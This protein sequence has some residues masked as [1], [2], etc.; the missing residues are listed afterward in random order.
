MHSAF[1]LGL[2]QDSDVEEEEE[3]SIASE[4][5]R[6]PSSAS[7]SSNDIPNFSHT[8]ESD[9]SEL[10]NGVGNLS[11]HRCDSQVDSSVKVMPQLCNCLRSLELSQVSASGAY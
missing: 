1:L 8:D 7:S 6:S 4:G 3:I 11:H 10:N 9:T 2:Y 5:Q